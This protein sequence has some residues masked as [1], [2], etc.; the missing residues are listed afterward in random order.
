MKKIKKNNESNWINGDDIKLSEVKMYEGTSY[1]IDELYNNVE[2]II[3]EA[4]LKEHGIEK[5]AIYVNNVS[6]EKNAEHYIATVE[7]RLIREDADVTLVVRE[8]NL[9]EKK[10]L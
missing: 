6:I 2:N 9:Y 1:I 3:E 4:L 7:A 5:N 10:E 8:V